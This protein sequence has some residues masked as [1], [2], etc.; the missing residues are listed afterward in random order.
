LNNQNNSKLSRLYVQSVQEAL[1]AANKN[2][3]SAVNKKDPDMP[4]AA[5]VLALKCADSV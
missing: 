1:S 5:I 3:H 4:M 2:A